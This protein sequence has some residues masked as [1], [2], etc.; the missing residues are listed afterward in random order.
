MIGPFPSFD[1]RR[2]AKLTVAMRFSDCIPPQRPNS[3]NTQLFVFFPSPSRPFSLSVSLSYQHAPLSQLTATSPVYCSSIAVSVNGPPSVAPQHPFEQTTEDSL[4]S[5]PI[6]KHPIL[7]R[8]ATRSDLPASFGLES[9]KQPRYFVQLS[10]SSCDNLTW[11]GSLQERCSNPSA[12]H[13]SVK[14]TQL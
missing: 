11:Q 7:L 14:A 13:K 6:L 1:P 8:F 5:H 12:F 9:R 3:L 10:P 4:A 2:S